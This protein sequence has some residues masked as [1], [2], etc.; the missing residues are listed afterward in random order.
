MKDGD[1]IE[2]YQ[3]YPDFAPYSKGNI[4]VK[5]LDGGKNDMDKIYAAIAKEEGF[6]TARGALDKKAAKDF[7]KNRGLIAHHDPFDHENVLY[8]PG[9]LHGWSGK[10]NGVR[11]MGSASMMRNGILAVER[12]R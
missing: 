6:I 8:V 12:K 9:K 3:G 10:Y 4:R 11:H 5:G 7:L 1:T 2:F